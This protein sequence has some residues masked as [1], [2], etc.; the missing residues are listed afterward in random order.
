MDKNEDKTLILSYVLVESTLKFQGKGEY[1]MKLDL[2]SERISKFLNEIEWGLKDD[3]CTFA[4][5]TESNENEMK[6][7]YQLLSNKYN[8]PI[9]IKQ[10]EIDMN[11]YVFF[12]NIENAK[13]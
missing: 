5:L 3:N 7:L 6:F 2:N 11:K 12:I 1:K 4:T 9:R 8:L 10:D 13:R